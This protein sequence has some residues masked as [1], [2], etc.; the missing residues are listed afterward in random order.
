[1][2]EP[3]TLAPFQ[4]EGVE[5]ILKHKHCLLADCMGLGK[6]IQSMT[7]CVRLKARKLLIICPASIVLQWTRVVQEFYGKDF[8]IFGIGESTE[9]N[10][11]IYETGFAVISSYNMASKK[12]HLLDGINFD[13]C[14]LDESHALKNSKAKRTKAILGKGSFLANCARVCL[15]T[16]TP[17]LNRPIDVY[18]ILRAFAL[19]KLGKYKEYPWF[20]RRF[21][22]Y[23]GRGAQNTEELGKILHGFMIRRTKE[24]VW[25]Q[26]PATVTSRVVLDNV[27]LPTGY[28]KEEL[29][30][31]RRL[32]AEA[33]APQVIEYV[34]DKL[35]T[36]DKIVLIAY[37][38]NTI[39][40]LKEGL[41][42]FN[43]VVIQGGQ[44][45]VQKNDYISNF[46]NDE[47]CSVIIAQVSTIGFG[48]D[49]LQKVCD[50]MVFAE[51]D[52]S[53]S[54]L[55]QAVDRLRR[56]GQEKGTIFVDFCI[57]AGTME[58]DIEITLEWKKDVIHKI[59]EVKHGMPHGYSERQWEK[60]PEQVKKTI[61]AANPNNP[62]DNGGPEIKRS[63]EVQNE[64]ELTTT[65]A[66][67]KKEA[68]ETNVTSHAESIHSLLP[69]IFD[70]LVKAIAH[71]VLISLNG[72]LAAANNGGIVKQTILGNNL[73]SETSALVIPEKRI[74]TIDETATAAKAL[75]TELADGVAVGPAFEAAKKFYQEKVLNGM[76]ST[77]VKNLPENEVQT[78]YERIESLFSNEVV[79]A[80]VKND[81]QNS[82]P[83]TV[84]DEV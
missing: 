1:M 55:A 65:M 20:L 57:A 50:R 27:N 77:S 32:I 29:P 38:T 13:F 36:V 16:G 71:E 5:Y 4:E 33:K 53:P 69:N 51:L 79:L 61:I 11:R 64:K 24:E 47:K 78:V 2:I 19:S 10:T 3:Y 84:E 62:Y 23:Q 56:I 63:Y 76:S 8:P 60:F 21:C 44:S 49:G 67:P 70:T 59:V 31:Q 40:L 14:I 35:Q 68:G 45:A 83:K 75:L 25:D 15:M 42:E 81:I 54:V 82:L 6:T 43:P 73:T 52:W 7:A 46:I 58:E 80:T 66:K 9:V 72:Q 39:A 30:T 28:D 12:R 37:H 74:Y 22:G 34:K 18:T 41:L 48:V 26:L 17:I